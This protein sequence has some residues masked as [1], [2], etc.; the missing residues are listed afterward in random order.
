MHRWSERGLG[1]GGGFCGFPPNRPPPAPPKRGKR[2]AFC[3]GLAFR[4]LVMGGAGA[5]SATSPGGAGRHQPFLCF[6]GG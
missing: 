1:A 5:P 6:R 2:V 3:A 4:R